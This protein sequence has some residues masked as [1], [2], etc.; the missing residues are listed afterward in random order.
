MKLAMDELKKQIEFQ[1]QT[2]RFVIFL[3][4]SKNL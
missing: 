3:K 2:K 1:K 4:Y